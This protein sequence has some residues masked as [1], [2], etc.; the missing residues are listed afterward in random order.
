MRLLTKTVLTSLAVLMLTPAS[1]KAA[2]ILDFGTG[3][4]GA[5]GTLTI[6]AHDFA[7]I[8]RALCLPPDKGIL[9]SIAE[10]PPERAADAMRWLDEHE[11]ELACASEPAP[12]ADELLRAL[13]SQGVR[14]GIVTRNSLRNLEATL[15]ATGL[16]DY[17]E[18]EK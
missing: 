7:A 11:Y 16:F 6:G 1:A 15:R 10:L 8:R 17:F 9:E 3:D 18:L 5:G 4:A 13:S 12:G 14:L 2:A